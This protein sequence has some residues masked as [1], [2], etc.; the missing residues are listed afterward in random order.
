MD[1]SYILNSALP[2]KEKLLE[3]GFSKDDKAGGG[4]DCKKDIQNGRFYVF[5]SFDR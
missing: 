2:Q 5:H 4:L 3:Y 1:Y